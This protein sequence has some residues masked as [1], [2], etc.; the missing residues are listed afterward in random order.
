MKRYSRTT[1]ARAAI[2]CVSTL[3]AST[4][5]MA[6]EKLPDRVQVSWAP[7]EQLSEVKDNQIRRG[8]LPTE[9]WEKTL[10]DH[11]RKRADRVLP[12]GEQLQVTVD[13]I[14]LAGSFEPWHGPNSE[15]I[16]FLKDIYPPRMNLHFKLL[17]SD[18]ATIREG[19]AKLWDS[20]YLQ[21]AV[22]GDSSDPLRYDK[23]LIDDWLHKEFAAKER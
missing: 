8:W 22:P 11:L 5:A 2:L 13:D 19:S 16:R 7:A 9:Q 12:P 4:A 6:T 10:S 17:A 23:R 1:A 21:R 18:G 15:D 3:I 20:A 14:H